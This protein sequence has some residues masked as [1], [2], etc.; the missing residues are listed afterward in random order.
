MKT[1]KTLQL[2]GACLALSCSATVLAAGSP[3]VDRVSVKVPFYDLDVQSYEGAK[4]LY[5]RLQRASRRACDL[6]GATTLREMS[7][8]RRCYA[9]SL[10]AAVDEV[11]SSMLRMLHSG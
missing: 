2:L 3:Q 7:D 9:Q 10:S 6:R 8:A 11:D 4:T 5:S 1:A